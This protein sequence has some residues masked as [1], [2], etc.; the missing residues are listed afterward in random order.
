MS[1]KPYAVEGLPRVSRIAVVKDILIIGGVVICDAIYILQS[2]NDAGRV[3]MTRYYK[4]RL[5]ELSPTHDW[6]E[7]KIERERKEE[8]LQL[9]GKS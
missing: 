9:P 4:Y 3:M 5:S 1:Q 7:L 6:K 8:E 2:I